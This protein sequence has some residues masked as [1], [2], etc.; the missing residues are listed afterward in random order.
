MKYIRAAACS[1]ENLMAINLN[2][3]RSLWQSQHIECKFSCS[4]DLH[5][6]N[7]AVQRSGRAGDGSGGAAPTS[8]CPQTFIYNISVVSAENLQSLT[9]TA[10]ATKL[11]WAKMLNNLEWVLGIDNRV[12]RKAV[13]WIALIL[14]CRILQ[15]IMIYVRQDMACN[16]SL[17]QTKWSHK[18]HTLGVEEAPSFFLFFVFLEALSSEETSSFLPHS[19]S[20]RS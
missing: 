16:G 12:T 8:I 11:M 1:A 9:T 4:T 13:Q 10:L 15:F 5:R 18:I 2:G 7:A 19:F 14:A 6:L 20:L 17:S 3:G